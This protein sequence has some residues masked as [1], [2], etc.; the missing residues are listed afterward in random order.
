MI[1]VI[2]FALGFLCGLATALAFVYLGRQSGESQ[3]GQAGQ[4]SKPAKFTAF[5][6][7]PDN[8]RA[9]KNA[10]PKVVREIEEDIYRGEVPDEEY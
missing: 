3:T 6:G 2:V 5:M 10:S 7:K 9:R 8:R 4:A 1:E